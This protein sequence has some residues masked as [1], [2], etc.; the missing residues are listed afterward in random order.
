MTHYWCYMHVTRYIIYISIYICKVL[1]R[2]YFAIDILYCRNMLTVLDGWCSGRQSC[3]IDVSDLHEFRSVCI[4]D[5]PSYLQARYTCVPGKWKTAS[6]VYLRLL[7][8]EI[9]IQF[10]KFTTETNNKSSK[11]LSTHCGLVMPY[12]NLDLDH[13]CL[14]QGLGASASINLNQY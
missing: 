4:M 2:S 3:N 11:Y 14:G 9:Y 5:L 8:T 7:F 6:W 10:L 1:G 13:H 12:G